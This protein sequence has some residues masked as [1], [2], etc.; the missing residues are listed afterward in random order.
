M[1]TVA[2]TGPPLAESI[3]LGLFGKPVAVINAVLNPIRAVYGKDVWLP[4]EKKFCTNMK[5][6]R[7][8]CGL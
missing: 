2:V 1:L 5:V 8:G 4:E 6:H 3:V 7:P